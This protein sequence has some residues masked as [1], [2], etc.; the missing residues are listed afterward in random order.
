MMKP[1]LTIFSSMLL[2]ISIAMPSS[3]QDAQDP[4][5]IETA[6]DLLARVAEE[7]SDFEDYVAEIVMTT[8]EDDM[9]GTFYHKE[10]NLL[11]IEFSEPE[12]QFI[13]SDGSTLRVHVP[14][15]NTTLTQE[16]RRQSDATPGSVATGDGLELLTRNFSVAY[17][18]SPE[19]VNVQGTNGVLESVGP[20]TD[21]VN[22]RLDTNSPNEGYRQL[23]LSIDSDYR[24]RRILGTT[25]DNDI[26]QFDFIDIRA[27]V[28]VP[29]SRFDYESP[30]ASST[31]EDFLFES[32]G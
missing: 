31:F 20:D 30:P 2:L 7:Y 11:Y 3:A 6:S 26:V 12:D 32:D 19:Y 24:I 15:L 21:V 13:L 17:Q 9:R 14:S 4:Q 29:D 22:L 5:D 27:N 16:L 18:D 8:E 10:P 23:I 1:I 25:V 28:S